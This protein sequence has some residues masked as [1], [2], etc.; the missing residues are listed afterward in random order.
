MGY[1]AGW[2]TDRILPDTDPRPSHPSR[3]QALKALGN[4]V[5]PQQGAAAVALLEEAYRSP[6]CTVGTSG[7]VPSITG[8]D[9]NER[10]HA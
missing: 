1:P 4:A 6:A 2:V 10:N 3:T 9:E 5:V 8:P 7:P